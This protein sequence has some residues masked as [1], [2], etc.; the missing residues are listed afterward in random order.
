MDKK[1]K[2]AIIRISAAAILLIAGVLTEKVLD[3][4]DIL[5][6][7][8]FMSAYLVAGYDT[9]L[10]AV[11]NIR[12]GQI[13][14]E[15]FLMAIATIGAIGLGD[16]SEAV[17]VMLFYLIGETFENY[18]VNRSRNSISELMDIRPDHANLIKDGKEMK[19]D[20]YDVKKDDVI[21]IKPGERIPLDGE[22]IEGYSSVD[23]SSLTGESMPVDVGT[24]DGINSGC[25]NMT[26]MLKVRVSGE[27]EDS[28]VAKVLDMVENAG[29]RKARVEKFITKFARYYT[30]VVVISAAVMALLPPLSFPGESFSDWISR[31]L[32]FLVISCPC[33]LVISVPLAFFG[34]V[35]GASREG[36]LV[37][38]TAFL[39]AMADVDTVI[40]DKTGTITTGKFKVEK[41]SPVDMG[42]G[43]VLELAAYVESYSDHPISMSIKEAYGKDIDK[44]RVEDVTELAGKGIRADIGGRTVYVGNGRLMRELGYEDLPEGSAS[45]AIYVADEERYLG[46]ISI[47]DTVKE[48]SG[49]SIKALEN[50]GV[51]NTIMLTGDRRSVAEKVAEEVGVD[52]VYSELLPGDKL[53]LAENIIDDSEAE[54]SKGHVVF[55][56]DGIN[57]APTL[58]RAD[59]G[60]AMGGLGSDAAIEAADII[61][62]DDDLSKISKVIDIAKNTIRIAKQNVVFALSVKAV[63]MIMGAFG[64]ANMWEAVFAD[65]GVAVI[66]ILNSMRA[67]KTG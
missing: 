38:G 40:F 8:V 61:I 28:T 30:P 33:A 1:Q 50:S 26:G 59:V 32:I 44:S 24:G 48:N 46:C 27:Y 35:G 4:G 11:M 36:I 47:T 6:V 23:T 39:E 3:L 19:V 64:V 43:E 22:I 12:R 13:F 41:V 67:M 52:R 65:V 49:S 37:K 25:L 31:A 57:D 7:A 66:A 58:A 9:L 16:Y 54:K 62:M 21:I 55:V 17:F 60:I 42:E 56:G 45:T 18:A 34:G 14:D 2:T 20:P 15:N 51:R 10:E 5:P 53:E 29:N 63:V